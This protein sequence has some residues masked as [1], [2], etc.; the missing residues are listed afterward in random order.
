M[1]ILTIFVKQRTYLATLPNKSRKH[2]K[3]PGIVAMGCQR[4]DLSELDLKGAPR[5]SNRSLWNR[6]PFLCHPKATCL[7]QVKGGMNMGKRCLRSRPR[8]PTAKRQPSPRGLGHPGEVEEPVLSV[9][10]GTPAILVGRCSWD[11]CGRQ[12]GRSPLFI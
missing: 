7:W 8:G 12:T 9:A 6:Y 3:S 2:S 4:T 5:F 11:G 10:E 1:S